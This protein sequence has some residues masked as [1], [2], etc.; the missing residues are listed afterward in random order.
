LCRCSAISSSS[1]VVDPLEDLVVALLDFVDGGGVERTGRAEHFLEL[2]LH[3][4]CVL[5]EILAEL[6]IGFSERHRCEPLR[7]GLALPDFLDA[8]PGLRGGLGHATLVEA[9]VVVNC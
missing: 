5:F 1:A 9:V 3:D 8:S 2:L 7:D 6:T 4:G